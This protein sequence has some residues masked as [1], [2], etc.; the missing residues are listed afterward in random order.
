MKIKFKDLPLWVQTAVIAV[1]FNIIINLIGIFLF[2]FELLI[3]QIG[4]L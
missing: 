4:R 2:W 3:V 1:W